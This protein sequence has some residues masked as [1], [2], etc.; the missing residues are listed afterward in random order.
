[1]RAPYKPPTMA[2]V[3]TG[4]ARA[5]FTVISTFAGAGGSST[6]YRLAGAKILAVNEFIPAAINTYLA[7]YPWTPLLP[8]DIRELSGDDFLKAA[9]IER[10]ELDVLDGSPPCAS[11]SMSGKREK[12][13]GEVKKYSDT[14]QR[15]DDLFFEFARILRELQPMAF[16]GENVQGLT[17]GK[18]AAILGDGQDD[19]FG[20][21]KGTI[22]G[23]LEDCGYKVEARVLKACDYGVPQTRPRL[24]M[25]GARD[26]LGIRPTFPKATT[27]FDPVTLREALDGLEPTWEDVQPAVIGEQ[28]AVAK[29]LKRMKP[30]QAGSDV[31]ERGSYF[32]LKRLAWDEPVGT[33]CQS[34]GENPSI[35]CSH[36]HPEE[37]RKLTIPELKRVSSFPDDF[38][39]TG[40][41]GQQWERIGRAVPPLLMKAIAGHLYE[42]VLKA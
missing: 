11:F 2:D 38:V 32:N 9:R 6:G 33:V 18:A 39:V 16:I 25:L 26:D 3:Y 21:S 12:H 20:E 37:L 41:F 15:T 13:W 28:Y 30:G 22:L 23:V 29:L 10:G 34:H 17:V 4:E 35:A 24:I 8:G 5:L 31:H 27:E 40:D 42:T 36:V 1:M 14:E 7:N 19:L